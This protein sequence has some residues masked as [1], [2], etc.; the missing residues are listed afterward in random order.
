ME[1][2]FKI[3]FPHDLRKVQPPAGVIQ[4]VSDLICE[5]CGGG[6]RRFYLTEDLE[7]YAAHRGPKIGWTIDGEAIFLR[8]SNC[9]AVGNVEHITRMLGLFGLSVVESRSIH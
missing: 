6:C 3:A 4:K 7:G 8:M 1:L 2:R 5:E 9:P